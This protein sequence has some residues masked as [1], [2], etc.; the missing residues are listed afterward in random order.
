VVPKTVEMN[1]F[2][3]VKEHL[4][5]LYEPAR[6]LQVVPIR[7]LQRSFGRGSFDTE[8]FGHP[9]PA[10]IVSSSHIV[11]T[12]WTR[13][14]KD[15]FDVKEGEASIFRPENGGYR[16]VAKVQMDEWARIAYAVK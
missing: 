5:R 11:P 14:G 10:P 16:L 3:R 1:L 6:S 7:L 2:V 12:S 4:I 13:L 15:W 9:R 8:R